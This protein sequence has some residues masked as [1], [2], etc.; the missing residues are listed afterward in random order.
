MSLK[1]NNDVSFT[2]W[3]HKKYGRGRSY[4]TY[5][6]NTLINMI[7]MNDLDVD[8][9][10]MDQLYIEVLSFLRVNAQNGAFVDFFKTAWKLYQKQI[11]R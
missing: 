4:K 10:D 1:I 9:Q 5:I 3:L 8:I 11:I 7:I 6:A 2:E